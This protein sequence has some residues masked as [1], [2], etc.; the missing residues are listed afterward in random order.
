[1]VEACG[2][3]KMVPYRDRVGFMV[4]VRFAGATPK[5]NCL[6]IGFW[7][8]HRLASERFH[9]VETIYPN[10]HVHLVRITIPA[11]WTRR[12]NDGSRK[13]MRSDVRNT[14]FRDK[15]DGPSVSSR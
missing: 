11:S 7:L 2:P 13:P 8:P 15:A 12:S 3:V 10:A 4:R 6:E 9:K 5:R 14:S 1:M